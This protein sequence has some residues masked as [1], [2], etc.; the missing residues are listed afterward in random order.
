M[1]IESETYYNLATAV[2]FDEE[3]NHWEV[4]NTDK[5][6]QELIVDLATA[7][8]MHYGYVIEPMSDT[9]PHRAYASYEYSNPLSGIIQFSGNFKLDWTMET[10]GQWISIITTTTDTTNTWIDVIGVNIGTEGFLHIGPVSGDY[11]V[12]VLWEQPTLFPKNVGCG[13]TLEIDTGSSTARL[14]L[15]G[16]LIQIVSFTGRASEITK[17]HFGL[18]CDGS[19]AH[20]E[21]YNKNISVQKI[22]I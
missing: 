2:T 10:A 21:C 22:G 14:F 20:C 16:A 6:G 15:N 17:A 13:V 19:I 9:S 1:R 18:Y 5:H 3:V 8:S 12:N 11:E 4:A 7:K